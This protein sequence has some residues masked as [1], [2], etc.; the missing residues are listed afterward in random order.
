MME[1]MNTSTLYTLLLIAI[2]FVAGMAIYGML[3]NRERGA[4][5]AGCAAITVGLLVSFSITIV[6]ILLSIS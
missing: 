2:P 5:A 1:S 3:R 4:L 6:Y